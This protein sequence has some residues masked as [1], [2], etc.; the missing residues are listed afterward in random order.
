M[1]H[2]AVRLDSNKE[3]M[4]KECSELLAR[5]CMLVLLPHMSTTC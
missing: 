4:C 5:C 3:L 2:S 1:M